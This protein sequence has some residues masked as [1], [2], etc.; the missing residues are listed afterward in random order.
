MS[1]KKKKKTK[2]ECKKSWIRKKSTLK[3]LKVYLVTKYLIFK[4]L[5]P[6]H[7]NIQLLE[8]TEHPFMSHRITKMLNEE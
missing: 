7:L 4:K 8:L 3:Q 1:P 5:T 6:L 2:D